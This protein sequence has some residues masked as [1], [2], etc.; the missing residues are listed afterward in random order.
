M[1]R[2][3]CGG[4]SWRQGAA[5]CV[6]GFIRQI[7]G[8][9]EFIRGVYWLK[10]PDYADANALDATRA[11]PGFFWTGETGMNCLHQAVTETRANA[12]AHHYPA[13]DGFLE[14]SACSQASTLNR[15]R[16]GS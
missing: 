9:R 16:S 12:Y 10:M 3:G 14:T 6:E 15:F 13:I 1:L 2:Q 8:W 4:F 11:L 7:I 5:Q